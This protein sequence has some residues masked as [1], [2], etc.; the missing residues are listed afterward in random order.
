MRL[1]QHVVPSA[2]TGLV[3]LLLCAQPA[4]A[5]T[6]AGPGHTPPRDEV[7]QLVAR[8]TQGN[9]IDVDDSSGPSQGDEFVATGNL[10]RGS[11]TVGTYSE[12]CT[13]TRTAPLDEFDLQCAADMTLPNGQITLQ[14]RFT[15]T[16]SGPGE[17]DLAITGG[18][19]R[20]S[21]A[22]GFVHGVNVS[23]TETR[24]TVHLEH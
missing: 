10:D 6:A 13:I 23:D 12:I 7:F 1:F 19:G 5:A 24:L 3:A 14:G 18:T 4:S 17:I 8:Q 9:F 22:Q 11:I 16:A 15:V 21:T 20:Y 2:A